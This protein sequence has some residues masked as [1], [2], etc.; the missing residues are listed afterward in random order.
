MDLDTTLRDAVKDYPDMLCYIGSHAGFFYIGPGR[1]A[2]D[3]LNIIERYYLRSCSRS[4][5]K[6][7]KDLENAWILLRKTVL[8]READPE[9]E[10]LSEKVQKAA[11]LLDGAKMR[12]TDT[13]NR[14]NG[15]PSS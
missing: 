14:L 12:T 4:V 7:A 15:F 5:E 8:L 9:K 13:V 6:A 1:E 3:A 10:E 11:V 2:V